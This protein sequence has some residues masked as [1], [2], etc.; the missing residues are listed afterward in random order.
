MTPSKDF[1][2]P[3]KQEFPP[4]KL[5]W[6]L[7]VISCSSICLFILFFIIVSINLSRKNHQIYRVGLIR[8][9]ILY[10]NVS[11][12]KQS[13]HQLFLASLQSSEC[14]YLAWYKVF[15]VLR[16]SHGARAHNSVYAISYS[17]VLH[18]FRQR[19]RSPPS[20]WIVFDQIQ[21]I[22]IIELLSPC[23]NML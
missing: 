20:Q 1:N 5:Y 18:V 17:S 6:S 7:L 22:T 19:E 14:F 8:E 13:G 10:I 3:E 16:V 15:R 9:L 4:Q 12:L 11:Q 21:F 2:R 23:I